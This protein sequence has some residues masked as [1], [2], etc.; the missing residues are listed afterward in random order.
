MFGGCCWEDEGVENGDGEVRDMG[1]D[2]DGLGGTWE[3]EEDEGSGWDAENESCGGGPR[4]M[5]SPEGVS[6]AFRSFRLLD[7]GL[8][9]FNRLAAASSGFVSASMALR[10]APLLW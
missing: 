7:D 6:S 8:S 4:T 3:D 5:R 9:F 2:D 1:W 10:L